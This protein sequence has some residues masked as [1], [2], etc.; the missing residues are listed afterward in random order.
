MGTNKNRR[1]IKG[2]CM[3]CKGCFI[4]QEC[5][6]ELNAIQQACTAWSRGHLFRLC[7]KAPHGPAATLIKNNILGKTKHF[8]NENAQRL[9]FPSPTK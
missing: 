9:Q 2:C 7:S 1:L 4:I 5:E 3:G 8:L 6:W